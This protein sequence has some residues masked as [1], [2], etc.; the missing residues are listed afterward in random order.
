MCK[1]YQLV[2]NSAVLNGE[3]SMLTT[4][5]WIGTKILF[6]NWILLWKKF[7]NNFDW[8]LSVNPNQVFWRVIHLTRL[9]G[10]NEY[11]QTNIFLGVKL[12]CVGIMLMLI[13]VMNLGQV[14]KTRYVIVKIFWSN[15]NQ[16]LAILIWS[17]ELASFFAP[18]PTKWAL[19]IDFI[20]I[21]S[22]R[23]NGPFVINKCYCFNSAQK[24]AKRVVLAEAKYSVLNLPVL[25]LKHLS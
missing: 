1:W 18:Q 24:T 10:Q 4:I 8:Q 11:D 17:S 2:V 15:S 23:K 7:W 19:S 21:L 9:R 3:N 25:G 12:M 14:Q 5:L 6:K 22:A 16:F 13:G 20:D